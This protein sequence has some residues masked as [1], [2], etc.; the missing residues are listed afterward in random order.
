MR[1]CGCLIFALVLRTSNTPLALHSHTAVYVYTS[2][3]RMRPSFYIAA[4]LASKDVISTYSQTKFARRQNGAEL[5][6]TQIPLSR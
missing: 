4:S 5:S 3:D 6:T 2:S 1:T